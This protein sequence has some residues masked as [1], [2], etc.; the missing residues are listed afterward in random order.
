MARMAEPAT[1]LVRNTSSAA[2]S[3][4]AAASKIKRCVVTSS[5]NTETTPP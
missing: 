1:V 2:I 5:P 3:A 4:A